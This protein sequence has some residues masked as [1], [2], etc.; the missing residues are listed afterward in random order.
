MHALLHD[1]RL[2]FRGLRNS[3]AF[4]A[5]ALLSIAA[6]VGANTVVFTWMDNLVLD[7]YP[8]VRDPGRIVAINAAAANGDV[9]GAPPVAYP[10]LQEW[11]EGVHT[12]EG[13]AGYALRRFN[14]RMDGLDH[15]APLWGMLVTDN[16][17]TLLG[18]R[19]ALGRLFQPGEERAGASVA[20]LSHQF[21]M[22][23][24]AGDPGILGRGMTL[25]GHGVT[26][27]GVAAPQ[28]G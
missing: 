11:A 2:A 15:A 27:I 4:A 28:F 19:P 24:F 3:P 20:V 10:T 26:V 8:A 25:N 1:L 9:S 13:M 7:P 17:F 22:D 23:R 16:Y 18:V 6:A 14:L 21:W 5:A 12:L